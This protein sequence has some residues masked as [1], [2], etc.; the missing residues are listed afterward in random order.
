MRRPQTILGYDTL[1]MSSTDIDEGRC[2]FRDVDLDGSLLDMPK[3]YCVVVDVLRGFG[4]R[5]ED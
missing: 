4:I 2:G 3:G 5:M 1:C